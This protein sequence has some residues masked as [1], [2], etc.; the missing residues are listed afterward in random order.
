MPDPTREN[1]T[2]SAALAADSTTSERERTRLARFTFL[3]HLRPVRVPARSLAWTHTMGL[4]GSA[5]VLLVLLVLTGLLQ[6]LVYVPVPAQAHVAVATLEANV[7]FGA[8]IRGA[9]YWSANLLIA[10]ALLHAARVFL[11]GALGGVRRVNWIIGTGLLLGILAAAFTGYLLPWDQRAYWA[12]TIVTGMLE[13]VP[14]IGPSLR[15][16]ARGG[17]EIGGETLVLFYTLH[18]SV[19]PVL[20]AAVAS[21]HFWRVRRAGGVIEPPTDDDEPALPFLPHLFVRELAQALIV[22]AV[23]VVLAAAFGAP[24]G[25]VANPGMSPNPAKAPWYFVGFQELLIHLHPTVAVLLVPLLVLVGLVALPYL[26]AP[27]GPAGRWFLSSLGRRAAGLAAAV[28]VVATPA[29]VVVSDDFG[30]GAA[31]WLV[32]GVL[33]LLIVVGLAVLVDLFLRHALRAP[34]DERR[35]AVVVLVVVG[36]VALTVVAQWFRGAGM[37]LVWP[38]GA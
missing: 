9:H 27:V 17:Q 19:L 30:S 35:Q 5:L 8:L 33:P 34:R 4:G 29:L 23:V 15:A 7:A 24:L 20:L 36:F 11:T 1:T 3:T 26:T 22:I 37:A 38:W 10:V 32:G 21:W 14:L 18:T 16:V 6:M 28:A 12:V 13:Y 25:E 2:W 31:G